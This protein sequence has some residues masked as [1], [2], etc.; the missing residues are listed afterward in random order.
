M[1]TQGPVEH[2]FRGSGGWWGPTFCSVV[3][4]E[5]YNHEVGQRLGGGTNRRCDRLG[6]VAAHIMKSTSN[7]I[8][9]AAGRSLAS[10]HDAVGVFRVPTASPPLLLLLIHC[11]RQ[12]H[13]PDVP[14]MRFGLVL[15]NS[16]F[17]IQEQ[18]RSRDGIH[19]NFSL[20]YASVSLSPRD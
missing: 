7:R 5:L 9:M 11:Y 12:D 15:W 1:Y 13:P 16:Q 14:F 3:K 20:S 4:R 10:S 6:A 18:A 19:R 2:D 8:K 17:L